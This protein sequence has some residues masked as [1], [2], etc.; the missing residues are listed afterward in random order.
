[1]PRKGSGPVREKEVA[2]CREKDGSR[3]GRWE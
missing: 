3:P 2:S 1:V